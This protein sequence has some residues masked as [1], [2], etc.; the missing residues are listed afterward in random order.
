MSGLALRAGKWLGPFGIGVGVGLAAKEIAEAPP[1]QRGKVASRESGAFL[2]GL[3]GAELGAGAG[4][5]L[6]GGISGFLIGL[7]IVSGPIGWLRPLLAQL[8][9][10]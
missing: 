5:A 1:G 10:Q 6:A 3:L 9:Q 8:N 4:V 7:G 2:G